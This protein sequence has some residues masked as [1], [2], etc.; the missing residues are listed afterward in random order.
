MSALSLISIGQNPFDLCELKETRELGRRLY[1]R[2]MRLGQ[3]PPASAFV[4]LPAFHFLLSRTILR[5]RVRF[6][7]KGTK[8]VLR[9]RC[10]FV[11]QHPRTSW[12][13]QSRRLNR[14]LDI[15]SNLTC[16]F[17]IHGYGKESIREDVKSSVLKTYALEI[18]MKSQDG[19]D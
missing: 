16:T 8:Q 12:N 4:Q 19:I 7:Q 17:C 2:G 1:A 9:T 15:Q 18:E 6:E 10:Q 5:R 11:R 13:I 14:L 3:A